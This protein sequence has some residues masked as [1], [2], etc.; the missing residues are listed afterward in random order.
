MVWAAPLVYSSRP[1]GR[2]TGTGPTCSLQG[3]A[4]PKPTRHRAGG[5][6]ELGWPRKPL[7]LGATQSIVVPRCLFDRR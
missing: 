2:T 3:L 1:W 7:T 4:D 6:A 5:S